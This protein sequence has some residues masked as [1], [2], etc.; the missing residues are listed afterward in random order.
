MKRLLL[1]VTISTLMPAVYGAAGSGDQGRSMQ[2]AA[3]PRLSPF[4]NELHKILLAQDFVAARRIQVYG[5][6]FASYK[7]EYKPE[8]ELL[9]RPVVQD[10][11]QVMN[12]GGNAICDAVPEIQKIVNLFEL[13]FSFEKQKLFDQIFDRQS[14]DGKGMS[15]EDRSKL[16]DAFH[17]EVRK[18]LNE[19]MKNKTLFPFEFKETDK[20]TMEDNFYRPEEGSP[21]YALPIKSSYLMGAIIFTAHMLAYQYQD[22]KKQFITQ[23][24]IRDIITRDA[25]AE[26]RT[27]LKQE[28]REARLSDDLSTYFPGFSEK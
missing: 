20:A 15:L 2:V 12:L 27:L 10:Y 5:P 26:L 11:V 17:K 23:P 9:A 13:R 4:I 25:A 21:L 22:D 18:C 7:I 28:L 1:F 8:L 19:L 6:T 3:G 24:R 14:K 16:W